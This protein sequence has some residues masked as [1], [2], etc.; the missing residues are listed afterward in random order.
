LSIALL[1]ESN[2]QEIVRVVEI[3]Q[4]VG[5]DGRHP[6]HAEYRVGDGEGDDD[7]QD[8]RFL[9]AVLR[10]VRLRRV[11]AWDWMCHSVMGQ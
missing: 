7:S 5:R 2:S 1:N 4:A 9:A 3:G 11:R 8:D 6:I 10:L